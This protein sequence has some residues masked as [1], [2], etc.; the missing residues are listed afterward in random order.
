MQMSTPYQQ[1]IFQNNSFTS[2][3]VYSS[4]HSGLCMYFARI[5][6]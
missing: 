4:K 3:I 1:S 6:R 2:D 5:L